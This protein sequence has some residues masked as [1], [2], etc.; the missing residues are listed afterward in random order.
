MTNFFLGD[1][2][3]H[4]QKRSNNENCFLPAFQYY[5]EETVPRIIEEVEIKKKDGSTVIRYY[6][7][8]KGT[9]ISENELPNNPPILG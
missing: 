8:R 5:F 4:L 7:V 1:V 6:D 2:D 9:F 3:V